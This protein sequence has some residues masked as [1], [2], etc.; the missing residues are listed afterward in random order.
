MPSSD[1]LPEYWIDGHP[2]KSVH[3]PTS[4]QDVGDILRDADNLKKPLVPVGGGSSLALGNLPDAL[5][6]ALDMS[7]IN[8][9]LHFEPADLTLSVEA[10]ARFADVQATLAERGQTLPIEIPDADRATIGGLIATALAGPRRLGSGTLRDLLIGISVAYPS[11]I[12]AKAGGL[13][14]KNVTGFDMMRL[15]HGA[16]G[17]LGVIVTANFKSRRDDVGCD[18]RF[19]RRRVRRL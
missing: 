3:R 11:G 9:V 5:D 12:V 4:P 10:G 7:A 1:A 6:A 17:T 14:V 13:V 16:L 15:H 18:L 8:R 19:I 2:L